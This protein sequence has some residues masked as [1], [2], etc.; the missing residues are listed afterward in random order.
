MKTSNIGAVPLKP[1]KPPAKD[2][3]FKFSIDPSEILPAYLPYINAKQGTQLIIGTA[4]SGK[5]EFFYRKMIMYALGKKYFRCIFVRKIAETIRESIFQGLKDVIEGWKL[6]NYFRVNQ[7]TM[8]I[9]CIINGNKMYGRG[10]DQPKKLKSVKDPS[11]IFWDEFDESES[12]DYAELQ[13]R[14]RTKKVLN[15]Q[16]W[17]ALNP[18]AGW[19]GKDYFFPEKYHEILPVGEIPALTSDTLILKTTYKQNPFVNAEKTEIKNKE[20]A[21]LDENN[22]TVYELGN[23]GKLVTGGEFYKTFKKRLVVDEVLFKPYI[24]V[25]AALD[26]NVLPYMTLLG[27]QYA[28]RTAFFNKEKKRFEP[29]KRET[30]IEVELHTVK[31]FKEYCLED[32]FN[33]TEAVFEHLIMDYGMEFTDV[34]YYGDAMGNKRH[35]GT[36]NKTEFKKVPELLKAYGYLDQSYRV[37]PSVLMRRTFLN[38]IFA[39]HEIAPGIMI[40]IIIDPK[41][42]HLIADL[43]NVKLGKD[44]KL[45]EMYHNKKTGQKY[46]KYGHTSDAMDYV[47]TKMFWEYFRK[48]QS[49]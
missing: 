24:T 27:S 21:E 39:L 28:V 33:T 25:H 44:G 1:V 38:K 20:L 7:Q 12:G 6:S 14:L 18:V 9:T 43:E 41:C 23:W 15:T 11:H 35:E 49:N 2:D 19:W 31:F 46:E 30:N 42:K 34:I 32:P 48:V 40:Q 22:W 37:N 8:T 45:K 13:R 4:A 10:V 47:I 16:F 3:R 36:G 29:V 17:A 5:S 26:F